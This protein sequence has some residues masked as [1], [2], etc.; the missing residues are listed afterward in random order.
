MGSFRKPLFAGSQKSSSVQL[1][2][3]EKDSHCLKNGAR[4]ARSRPPSGGR[5]CG[6]WALVWPKPALGIAVGDHGENKRTIIMSSFMQ[7][8][9]WFIR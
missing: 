7:Q 3:N 5:C 9:F 6:G 2:Q 8:T 1:I 4:T